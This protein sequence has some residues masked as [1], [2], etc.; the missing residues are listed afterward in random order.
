MYYFDVMPMDIIVLAISVMTAV[1]LCALMRK[2]ENRIYALAFTAVGCASLVI[3]FGDLYASLMIPISSVLI[4]LMLKSG[5][6]H[7]P[8]IVW[9]LYVFCLGGGSLLYMIFPKFVQ[10]IRGLWFIEGA[11]ALWYSIAVYGLSLAFITAATIIRACRHKKEQRRAHNNSSER[12]ETSVG[13]FTDSGEYCAPRAERSKC[14]SVG[15]FLAFVSYALALF[16]V[17]GLFGIAAY[18]REIEEYARY[19]EDGEWA[20]Y[21]IESQNTLIGWT[22]TTFV[23]AFCLGIAAWCC[24]RAAR[25]YGYE[26]NA[27]TFALYIWSWAVIVAAVIV[28]IV[29]IIVFALLG[30]SD[31]SSV[32]SQFNK[33]T[34]KVTDENGEKRTIK[35][36]GKSQIAKC[37]D[38]NGDTWETSDGGAHFTKCGLRKIK[39]EDGLDKYI[40]GSADEC[41]FKRNYSDKA[42][43]TY[44]S[45]D[46]GDTVRR[47]DAD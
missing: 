29:C 45:D 23:I 3:V 26:G 35:Y 14:A 11:V 12:R 19:N 31:G 20:S 46:G 36:D 7:M 22:I 9:G 39:D 8:W 33:K 47:T 13:N 34:Y 2:G 1:F 28:I 6:K 24:I 10:D 4:A 5:K 17:R 27:L 32:S 40:Y 30:S 41:G 18:G 42:G 21:L 44:E 38:D 16:G 43:N 25:E 15:N 37:V